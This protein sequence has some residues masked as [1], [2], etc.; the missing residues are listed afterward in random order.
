MSPDAF[1]PRQHILRRIGIPALLA[2][3]AVLAVGCATRYIPNTQIRDTKD[4]REILEIVRKY[5]NAFEAQDAQAIAALASPRYLDPRDNVSY[6]TLISDLEKDFE[7]VRQVQLDIAVRRINIERDTATVDYFY[8]A[9]ALIRSE[10]EDRW[11]THTDDNRMTLVY[12]E[13]NWRVV[14]G[15]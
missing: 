15:F 11:R 5:K 6:E 4:N 7:L 10:G 2:A 3:F 8:S 12:D 14:S 13:G 1:S 9:N